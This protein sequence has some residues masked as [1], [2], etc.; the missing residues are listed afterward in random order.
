MKRSG[1]LSLRKSR[2]GLTLMLKTG[3]AAIRNQPR[4]ASVWVW[5]LLAVIGP[6]PAATPEQDAAESQPNWPVVIAQLRQQL[7]RMPGSAHLHQQL[8]VAHNNYG[9]SLG[10]HGRLTEATQQLEEAVRLDPSNSQFRHNLAALHL[11][12]AHAAYR[13]HQT[14][15]AKE[16][17]DRALTAEP[18]TA[19][20]YALLGEIEYNSQ[21]LKEAK[22][23]W[24]QALAMNPSLEDVRQRLGQI[25][26][27]L[28]V[29]SQFER[30]S[31]FYFDIR[32]T[33]TLERSAGFDIQE[34]LLEARRVIGSDFAYWPT[35]KLVVL[36]YSAQQFRQ[37]RQDT[38][39][40]V[41]GQFD[42]KI[43][44]PL[45]GREFDQE[46]VTRILF[47]EYTHAVVHDLTERRCPAWL[48]EGLAEYEAWKSQQ[49]P[50][51]MLRQAVA[52]GRL[53]PWATLSAQFS[54]SSSAQDA[55]LAYE[56]S[57]SI[58]RYLV[59]RYGFWRI[60]RLLQAVTTGTPLD[61]A[62]ATEFHLKPTRL[63]DNWRI[64][65]QG[66]Q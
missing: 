58:V 25:T 59:E 6:T 14:Q 3:Q 43:R 26:Q 36:V 15:G 65:L 35:H 64:W 42:G 61:V 60:R 28:P 22:A 5:M 66:T 48:N 39:E 56:Q 53:I 47:H 52:T 9:V 24:Q 12:A 62:M 23:A 50:W 49:P 2:G 1:R 46:T 4:H 51:L 7:D 33:E 54:A 19:E 32:Y 40:W 16:A 55:A 44:I 38:P 45:P 30:L 27:E 11:Q 18:T 57:H 37:L 8:A 13:A 10:E 31:Q 34:T 41:A 20:A 21:R 29:E 63:E 17:I